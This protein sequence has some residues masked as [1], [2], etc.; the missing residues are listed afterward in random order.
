MGRATAENDLIQPCWCRGVKGACQ[1]WLLDDKVGVCE[2][3]RLDAPILAFMRL[4]GSAAPACL[5]CTLQSF[6]TGT[7]T[8]ETATEEKGGQRRAEM[9][10]DLH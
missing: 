8:D 4:D 10:G 9:H 7:G 3:T 2:R 5:R 6:R 1:F